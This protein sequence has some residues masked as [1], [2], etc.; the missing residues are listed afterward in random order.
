MNKGLG[1][2]PLFAFQQDSVFVPDSLTSPDSLIIDSTFTAKADSL[3][4]VYSKGFLSAGY[5]GE[6]ITKEK[7]QKED[8]GM[9]AMYLSIQLLLSITILAGLDNR[10]KFLFTGKGSKMFL[11]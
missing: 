10:M 8:T 7:F 1:A 9:R 2:H 3:I 5:H 6:I 11:I 4:P